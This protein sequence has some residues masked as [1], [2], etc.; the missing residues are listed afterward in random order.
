MLENIFGLLIN[1]I[2]YFFIFVKLLFFLPP[3]F[4]IGF[5]IFTMLMIGIVVLTRKEKS[6]LK[7]IPIAFLIFIVLIVLGIGFLSDYLT[8]RW[9]EELYVLEGSSYAMGDWSLPVR[10]FTVAVAGEKFQLRAHTLTSDTSS[11]AKTDT[12]PYKMTVAFEKGDRYGK[13]II[14]HDMTVKSDDGSDFPMSFVEFPLEIPYTYLFRDNFDFDFE[15]KEEIFIT[16]DIEVKKNKESTREE[17]TL[18]LVPFLREGEK[19]F[20]ATL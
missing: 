17:I 16:L 3:Y 8:T 1:F 12:G 5:V 6:K 13:E 14:I 9:H 18:K 20:P 19:F 10:G 2:E 7:F 15:K 11:K 4:T